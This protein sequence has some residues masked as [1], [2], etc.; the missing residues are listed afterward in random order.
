MRLLPSSSQSYQGAYVV[1]TQNH[2]ELTMDSTKTPNLS[3]LTGSVEQ[4]NYL[5]QEFQARFQEILATLRALAQEVATTLAAKACC[6][7]IVDQ[8]R[9]EVV[10]YAWW[11]VPRTLVT[12]TRQAIGTGVAGSAAALALSQSA[13]VT[14][15]NNLIRVDDLENNS[16]F[17]STGLNIYRDPTLA[18]PLTAPTSKR[19]L[20]VLLVTDKNDAATFTAQ[21]E[22]LLANFVNQ[23]T[24][25]LAIQNLELYREK[26]YWAQ[27]LSAVAEVNQTLTTAT[28]LV[29]VE[30]TCRVI[31]FL[32]C[33]KELF[34]FDRAE[35]CLW[36]DPTQTLTTVDLVT[37]TGAGARP[38]RQTYH[39][40][41]G[42]TG[43]L[44]AHQKPLLIRDTRN[45]TDIVPKVG[46]AKFPYR[47]YIGSPLKSGLK[48]VGTLELVA[49]PVNAYDDKDLVLLELIAN[50]AAI[51]ISHIYLQQEKQRRVSELSLLY[52]TSRELSSTVSYTALLDN[53][54]RQMID[55]FPIANKAAIFD[56]DEKTST[57]K[58]TQQYVRPTWS[59]TEL[60]D[61]SE[62]K[63]PKPD[64]AFDTEIESR[65]LVLMRYASLQDA[66]K[67]RVPVVIRAHDTATSPAELELLNSGNYGA[68]MAVPLV[69]RDKV[70]GLL[71]MF[72]RSPHAFTGG[73][74]RLAQSLANQAN[75][76]LENAR[77]LSLSDQEL[78]KRVDELAG[79]QRVSSELT[80]TL[81]LEKILNLILSE[82]MHITQADFGNVSLYEA[83]SGALTT[84]KI[85]E[86]P[87]NESK[88]VANLG[89]QIGNLVQCGIILRAV[90]TQEAILLPDVRQD[91]DYIDRGRDTRSEIV[92]PI[93]Y[94]EESVG[95]INLESNSFNF[96]T[97]DHLGYLEALVNQAAVAIANAQA[98]QEQKLER[99]RA[100]RR[101]DQLSRLSEVSNAFRT[102]RPLR[103]V[104]EDIAY[105]VLESAGFN[106][107]LISLVDG[108][109]PVV[110]PEI[111]AGVPIAQFEA[112]KNSA[113]KQP[114]TNLKAILQP[115]F[116]LQDDVY[117]IPAEQ[118]S[119]WQ[120]KLDI[121]YIE[122][123]RRLDFTP[124]SQIGGEASITENAWQTGDLL[125]VPITDTNKNTIGLLT[126]QNPVSDQRPDATAVQALG[127]FANHAAVAIENHRLFELEQQR[128]RLADTLREL[129]ETISSQL[130]IDEL[131]NIVQQGLQNVVDYDRSTVELLRDDQVEII[132]GQGWEEYS[133]QIIGLTFSMDTANPSWVVLETQDPVIIKDARLAYPNIFSAP[134]YDRIR[135]WLGVPLTYGANILGL[136]SIGSDEVNYF[137]QEDAELTLVFANQVAVALQNARLFDEARQQVRQLA[138]LTEVAQSIN[139]SLDLGE[140]L[141]L[142]LDAVF[143]LIGERQGAVWLLDKEN[144]TIKIANTKNIHSYLVELF[145]ENAIP[146]N[147]E[148][149]ASVIESGQV[150]IIE[151]G[152]SPSKNNVTEYGLAFPNNV[153]YVPLN[154]DD[155][156]IG[157]LVIETV[158]HNQNMLKLVTT[159]ADLA[160]VAIENAQLVQRLNQFNEEL[161]QRVALR[162][163][164][165]AKTLQ[166]LTEERDRV[167]TL[168]RITRELSASLDLDR[169]LIE[170]LNLINRAIG[171]SHGSILLL[172]QGNGELIYRAALGRDKPL[173]RGGQRT[174]Y[175]LGYGL[176]GT[177]M[178][179]GEPRIIPDLSEDPDWVSNKEL[180]DRR[181]ALAVP[182]A[183]G[184]GLMGAL[185]LYHPEHNFFTEDHLKLVAAAG[186]QI[187]NAISNAGLYR[188]ITDQAARLG[189]MLRSEATEAAKNQAILES[190]ADGVL[191][192][193]TWH[194]IVLL[195]PKAAEILDIDP[196]KVENQPID[197]ILGQS[198]SPV[199]L[200]LAQHFHDHLLQALKQIEAGVPSTEFRIEVGHKAVIVTLTPVALA[201]E[202]S[203]SVVAVL[204]DISKE[205][206]IERI[207]NE[208]ISTVSHELRTPMT[209]VKGYADLLV[210][211]N[212]QVGELNPTQHRF[213]E[214]IQ[215]NANRLTD[216]VNEIL[217][218]SRIETGRV[219]LQLE[220]IDLADLLNEVTLSFEGQLVQK[221]M[222]LVVE[223][224]DE[225]PHVYADKGRLTQIL[226]NLI[227][228]AWQYTSAGGRIIVRAT[229]ADDSY[230]QIDIKDTGI[231]IP[232][233][234]I[235]YV[236][237][238]FFRSERP[239]AQ[240][241]DGTG[242]GLSITKSYVDMLGG[243]IWVE[244]ELNVGT[245][246][247]FT[248]PL[249][250]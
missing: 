139:R 197:T 229:V 40:N 165:L 52:E 182:L 73:D 45:Q 140:V 118:M 194:N 151:E 244:S 51:V 158:I 60:P 64:L 14:S 146:T 115:E 222:D 161:E 238:R 48:F 150:S 23:P 121:P 114:V 232:E 164:E 149:F 30:S 47:T 87:A 221:T 12:F 225:L 190:V 185:V 16:H 173:P 179:L 134:P 169:V 67:T 56:F 43:W 10:P 61:L 39:L 8:K 68:M 50:Q 250:A 5:D 69:S 90:R 84:H 157:I 126:V 196:G 86:G 176:A 231:G 170:A 66:F 144:N 117:F 153:T 156:V 155:G 143:D 113:D 206:E 59:Q 82:A 78:Q 77:L 89:A 248:M 202:D 210:S 110:Y 35:I 57:L 109:P 3:G 177:V 2:K 175:R 88:D 128:R 223:L 85:Q 219:K 152:I 148:P 65:S 137:T 192:L 104:L 124:L 24:I 7:Y 1:T 180:P 138:A 129:A 123:P 242:L 17:K 201:S 154:S 38:Y 220:T 94:G 184:E 34:H 142:V 18:M 91:K 22:Q 208:F 183:T 145:N 20:G 96:F 188:L 76:A 171:I 31:L 132:G 28:H 74:I 241:A 79:L 130:E 195:N 209:S 81:D 224:P 227:G 217:E 120:D 166:D 167:E 26:H 191:V 54:S 233:Q 49:R 72:S 112:L 246:F 42:Y 243:E 204:R 44:A 203:L 162:T 199:E 216:L 234:D 70:T 75:I 205:A 172:D 218:I 147:V 212:A 13:D 207:K 240:M 127:I 133:E 97:Q 239:E 63:E 6:I 187:A 100:R 200:E 226:V 174:K 29:D 236:F 178:E 11:S 159:L 46:L 106:V 230:V 107:V 93:H 15:G 116:H 83:K 213:V 92:V 168:Y 36:D 55:V 193:D 214:V 163:E 119:V 125:L 27:G 189:V 198:E 108:D 32:P 71:E 4:N 237:D 181:S 95:V 160:A 131:L 247:S 136:M 135:S 111:G 245:T 141:N 235:E 249:T 37:E 98:F 80:S 105:A 9:Q 62:L 33:L 103:D 99:E 215:A 58:L 19:L 211:G 53:L 41:E 122:K 21:D 186:T 228:N 102:N 101:A 25:A